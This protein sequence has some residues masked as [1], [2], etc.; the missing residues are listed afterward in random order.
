M[1]MP[2]QRGPDPARRTWSAF[3]E[4]RRLPS[5]YEI[6]THDTNYTLRRNREAALEQ[7]PSSV[8][9][10]W[11]LT[12]RDRSPVQVD[13]W[14]GFRDPDAVTYRSYVTAQAQQETVVRGILEEYAAA[15][16]ECSLAP[17]WRAA[18]AALFTPLRFPLHGLQM[19]TA[20]F[21]QMAPSSYITNCAAFGAADL[22]RAVSIVAYRTRELERA[23]PGLGFARDERS[24]WETDAFWQGTRKAIELALTAYD[25]AESFTAVNLV[26]RP[27]LD[28]L[29]LHQLGDLARAN[30]D[31]ET[32]LLLS[33]LLLD[34][35]R[36][37]RWSGALA[38]FALQERPDNAAVFR[39]WIDKWE[40]RADAAAAGWA[41]A[42]A[43]M[44]DSAAS[45][46]EARA[47]ARRARSSFLEEL[48]LA[49]A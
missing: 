32:W 40:P 35:R 21:G 45:E 15:S 48:G 38:R 25:W 7:N 33:N 26:L 39:R 29:W 23:L 46:D 16:R 27:T 34:A 44:T 19:C 31:D 14:L 20:Y 2:P 17:K 24:R 6:V 41:T 37:R 43:S 9:N 49:S 22:L 10:L 5:E 36:A 18:L 4:V 42:L 13:D 47:G 30:G 28:D 3:G 1:T 8:G 12:Y 11:L